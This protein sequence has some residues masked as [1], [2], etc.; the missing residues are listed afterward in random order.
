MRDTALALTQRAREPKRRRRSA[1]AA[2]SIYAGSI[3]V[4]SLHDAKSFA[5]AMAEGDSHVGNL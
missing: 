4:H 5:F 2:H 1:L 3:K